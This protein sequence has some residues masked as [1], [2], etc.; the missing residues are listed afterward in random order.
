VRCPRCRLVE[1]AFGSA[2]REL[3]G[4]DVLVTPRIVQPE[5]PG[6][7]PATRST[8]CWRPSQGND[9]HES[10]RPRVMRGNGGQIINFGSPKR[11]GQ[12]DRRGIRRHQRAVQAWTRS[13][14]KR[15]A[16][17]GSPSNRL[18]R[19]CQTRCD[20]C[21]T[22]SGPTPPHTIDQQMKLSIRW[23][24][25]RRSPTIWGPVLV[26]WPALEPNYHRPAD[27]R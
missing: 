5:C 17:S 23:R 14:A 20:R 2:V 13:A 1:S 15:G 8:S 16:Q 27:T 21:E 3:G 9:P 4:L 10:G 11:D 19:R 24:Q 26:F 22:S 25:A 7:S 6:T 18:R 12:P